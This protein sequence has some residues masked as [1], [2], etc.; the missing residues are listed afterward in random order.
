MNTYPTQPWLLFT[1][2]SSVATTVRHTFRYF[3]SSNSLSG[4]IVNTKYESKTVFFKPMHTLMFT[5]HDLETRSE[6]TLSRDRFDVMHLR[7]GVLMQTTGGS[8]D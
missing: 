6:Y 7:A 1:T 5:N 2:L 8:W 4:R 3:L